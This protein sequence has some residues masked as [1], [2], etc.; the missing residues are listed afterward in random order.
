M[1]EQDLTLIGDGTEAISNAFLE[2]FG[3]D[4]NVVICCFHMRKNLE[5]NYIESKIKHYMMS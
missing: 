4:H 5:K 3:I 1:N 2:V